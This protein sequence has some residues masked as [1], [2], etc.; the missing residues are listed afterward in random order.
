MVK[1]DSTATI[2]P[3]KIGE[4]QAGQASVLEGLVPGELVI[5]DGSD[6]LREG[7]RVEIR[8][9]RAGMQVKTR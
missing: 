3:I 2:K 8:K 9:V 4:I 6:R 7:T 5:T 1:T